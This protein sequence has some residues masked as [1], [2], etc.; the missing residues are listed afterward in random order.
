MSDDNIFRIRLSLSGRPIKSYTFDKTVITVGRDPDADIFV[1][2]PS[3]SRDHLRFERM[4]NG[5]YSVCD[6]GSANGSYLN[7]ERM[8]NAVVYNNDV[9]RI[10]K[11]S[12][13]ISFER[14]RRAT[15]RGDR[16]TSSDK[17]EGTMM[18]SS[19]EM[20]HL[21]TIAREKDIV[22]PAMPAGRSA[23][24]HTGSAVV[25]R[26]RAPMLLAIGALLIL[27]T[28]AGAGVAWLLLR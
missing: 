25:R 23:G 18:L 7:E 27:A 20:E 24:P 17:N 2:N 14:D 21:I 11:F 19:T 4:P 5:H 26:S 9:I 10:G 12:L 16:K 3:I 1:D 13:W 6:M 22:P 28:S 8:Q 15:D